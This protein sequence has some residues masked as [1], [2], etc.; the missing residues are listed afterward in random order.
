MGALRTKKSQEKYLKLIANG[1]LDKKC[2]LCSKTK[3][4]SIKKFKYWR[5]VNNKFPYDRIAKINHILIPIRHTTEKNLNSAEK[6]ELELIKWGYVKKNY[7]ILVEVTHKS[8]P[9]HFHV[10]LIVIKDY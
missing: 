4:E 6:K 1:F 3:A 9:A 7:E 10:H 5:I 8:I 2:N